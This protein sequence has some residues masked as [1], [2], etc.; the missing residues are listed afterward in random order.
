MD[1]HLMMYPYYAYGHGYHTIQFTHCTV[2]MQMASTI[3]VYTH[4][5]Y[6][7]MDMCMCMYTYHQYSLYLV[8][9]YTYTNLLV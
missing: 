9:E 3:N 6:M 1:M 5:I 2:L 8:H 7:D 4:R